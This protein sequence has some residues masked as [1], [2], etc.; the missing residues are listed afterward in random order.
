MKVL[1]IG[2]G[3]SS[4][5]LVNLAV[6]LRWPDAAILVADDGRGGEAAVTE[7]AR[8][9]ESGKRVLAVDP[10]Y[11]GES[12]ITEK[13]FLFALL[14]SGVGD[15]P[16]GIQAGQI[17]AISRWATRQRQ[18]VTVVALGPRSSLFSLV[19]AALDNSIESLK[20]VGALGSLKEII[21]NNWSVREKP[22]LFCFGLLAEFDI[23]QLLAL[24]APRPVTLNDASDRARKELES[25]SSW[26]ATLGG[27]PGEFI[28]AADDG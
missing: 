16:L 15:R 7:A 13:D 24:V 17:S 3:F 8:L 18:R 1:C 23:L 10:F 14:V 6:R 2:H 19:A 26:Y 21:E 11:F 27:R 22:E 25:L 12:K 9:L 5:E 4:A 20:L 28:L